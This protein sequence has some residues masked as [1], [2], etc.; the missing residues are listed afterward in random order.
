MVANRLW[1][2]LMELSQNDERRQFFL[3]MAEMFAFDSASVFICL[4]RPPAAVLTG[5]M[6]IK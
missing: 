5:Q 6:N 1:V 2:A 4:D 3:L